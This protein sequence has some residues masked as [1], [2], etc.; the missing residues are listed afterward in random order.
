MSRPAAPASDP[1]VPIRVPSADPSRP[2]VGTILLLLSLLVLSIACDGSFDQGRGSGSKKD[3]TSKKDR[4]AKTGDAEAGDDETTTR[5]TAARLVRTVALERGEIRN[6]IET[7]G[8]VEAEYWADLHP[9]GAGGIVR[10]LHVDEGDTVRSG[11]VLA[12]LDDDDAKMR[13]TLAGLRVREMERELERQAAAIAELE[14]KVE[15]QLLLENRKKQEYERARDMPEG[16][17]SIEEIAEKQY[18]Y[19]DARVAHDASEL[20]LDQARSNSRV[21]S[22]RLE[23]SK[24]DEEIAEL[25]LEYTRVRAPIAGVLSQRMIRVGERVGPEKQVFTLVDNSKLI[26]YV[27]VPQREVRFVRPGQRAD[28]R[29]DAVPGTLFEGTVRTVS[30]VI[31]QGN[32][33]LTIDIANPDGLL[34]PGMFLTIRIILDVHE[35]AILIPKKAILHD[36][37]RPFVFAV[38]DGVARK[39]T[40][41]PGY[42]SDDAIEAIVPEGAGLPLG[43]EARIVVRGQENLKDGVRVEDESVRASDPR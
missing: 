4:T 24:V 12:T 19:E 8:D 5:E 41:E 7:S 31:D 34:L 13:V 40:F 25:E 14:R 2:P 20:A 11:D 16:V 43:A 38:V 26:T 15:Q 9:R 29:C 27:H 10:E 42:R 22:V 21:T 32:L 36:R 33:K 39:V 35:E 17:L 18:Q 6:E 23:Q 3:A 37:D 30:P 1:S 28:I